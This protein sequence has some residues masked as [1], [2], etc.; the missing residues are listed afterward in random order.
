MRDTMSAT[1]P[2]PVFMEQIADILGMVQPVPHDE[3]SNASS[4]NAP[5][6]CRLQL[7]LKRR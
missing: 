6:G 3:R 2:I 7:S 4:R 5:A 1:L